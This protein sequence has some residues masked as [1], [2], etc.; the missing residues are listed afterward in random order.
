MAADG[1]QAPGVIVSYTSDNNIQTG[2]AFVEVGL[3]IAAGVPLQCDE[4][5]DFKSFRLGLFGLEKLKNIDRTV[6]T[7]ETALNK[8][9]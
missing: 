5:D 7:L 8:V 9:C 3:Q 2:K 1:F 6:E 4:G